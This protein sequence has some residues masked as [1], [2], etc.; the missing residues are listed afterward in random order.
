MIVFNS[1]NK[2][3]LTYDEI[4]YLAMKIQDKSVAKKYLEDYSVWIL[5]KSENQ[6][7]KEEAT[8][9]AKSNLGYW[10][11]YYSQDERLNFQNIFCAEYLLP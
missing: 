2:A 1:K 8:D 3:E 7:S 9:I 5:D 10:S 4:G 11:G 6:I